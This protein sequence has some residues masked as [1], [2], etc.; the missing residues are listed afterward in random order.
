MKNN[1]RKY[2]L[3]SQLNNEFKKKSKIDMFKNYLTIP[4][5]YMNKYD[6]INI[7]ILS[8]GFYSSIYI[9]NKYITEYK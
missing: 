6:Y 8:L 7:A 9:Y 4:F 3:I 2:I 5:S 1:K